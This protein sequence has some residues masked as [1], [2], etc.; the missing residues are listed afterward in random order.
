MP[1]DGRLFT[2]EDPAVWRGIYDQYWTVIQAKSALN[3]KASGK[4]LQLDKWF[5]FLQTQT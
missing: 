2:C 4:L 3:G 5:E 1:V